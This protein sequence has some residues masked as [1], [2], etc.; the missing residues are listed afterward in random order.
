MRLQ[1]GSKTQGFLLS[2]SHGQTMGEQIRPVGQLGCVLGEF[3]II[4]HLCHAIAEYGFR[5]VN[6]L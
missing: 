2:R 3:V 5:I 1:S 4:A 6:E